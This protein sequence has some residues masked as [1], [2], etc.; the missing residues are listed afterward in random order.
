MVEDDKKVFYRYNNKK[1]KDKKMAKIDTIVSKIKSKKESKTSHTFKLNQ[2]LSQNIE[3]ISK[4]NEINKTE[5]VEA[6]LND[7]FNIK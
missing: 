7:Y 1:E 5:L 4:E 6:I 3:D 2:R